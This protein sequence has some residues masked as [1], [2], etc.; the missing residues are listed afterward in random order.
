MTLSRCKSSARWPMSEMASSRIKL[1]PEAVE[2]IARRVVVLL[3][4]NGLRR[5]ELIGAAELRTGWASTAPGSTP[6]R[7]SL[8]R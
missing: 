6:T 4:K 1:D 2:A 8:A 3:E 5:R 7:S